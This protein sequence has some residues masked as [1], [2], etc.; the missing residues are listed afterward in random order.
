RPT[1]ADRKPV[2]ALPCVRAGGLTLRTTRAKMST[3]LNRTAIACSW[4][5]AKVLDGIKQAYPMRTGRSTYQWHPTGRKA[6]S[7]FGDLR[8]L[9]V[10]PRQGRIEIA[11]LECRTPPF[12]RGSLHRFESN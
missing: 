1:S 5:A 10:P 9:T 8:A 12:G 7:A 4:A 6:Q 3:C 2:R 11:R